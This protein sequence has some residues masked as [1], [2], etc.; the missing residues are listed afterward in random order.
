MLYR[1]LTD[2]SFD[3]DS[4]NERK[5][6]FYLESVRDIVLSLSAKEVKDYGIA[7]YKYL[8]ES[9][10]NLDSTINGLYEEIDKMIAKFMILNEYR[11]RI[12]ENFKKR[13]AILDE[14]G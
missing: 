6:G 5:P 11:E 8:S 7:Y 13:S 2:E 3:I 4:C 12:N 9:K 14:Y 1:F 10:I